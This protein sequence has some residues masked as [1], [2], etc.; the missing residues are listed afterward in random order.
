VSKEI[1][2]QIMG[3]L[4]NA[5][6][7]GGIGTAGRAFSSYNGIE[8]A[9]KT[10]TAEV[11][12][13]Q[14]TSVFMAIVNPNPKTP[15]EPQYVIAVFVDQGGSGGSGGAPIARRIADGLSGNLAPSS[16]RL[17]PPSTD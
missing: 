12:G 4:I 11:Y 17:V 10:G 16:V 15:D 14:D 6:S 1:R 9:G 8:V 13:K 7:P 2:D 3:G 5:V